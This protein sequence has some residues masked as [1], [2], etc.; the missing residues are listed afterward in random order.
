MVIRLRSHLLGNRRV[1]VAVQSSR[2]AE[3]GGQHGKSEPAKGQ[4]RARCSLSA[5]QSSLM[6]GWP[7]GTEFS[8]AAHITGRRQTPGD[9]MLKDVKRHV[10]NFL[11]VTQRLPDAGLFGFFSSTN[12]TLLKSARSYSSSICD[13]RMGSLNVCVQSGRS[14]LAHRALDARCVTYGR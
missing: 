13:K 4:A 6:M 5:R 1:P 12:E 10:A 3:H 7:P 2:M 14:A 11:A 8:P 9:I